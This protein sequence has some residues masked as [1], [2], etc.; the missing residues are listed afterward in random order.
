MLEYATVTDVWSDNA[1]ADAAELTQHANLLVAHETRTA[2][3]RPDA[4]GYPA[5]PL[6]R[7]VFKDAVAAQAR[8]W[9]ENGLKPQNGVQGLPRQASSKSIGSGSI[10]YEPTRGRVESALTGLCSTSWYMLDNAGLLN[11]RPYSV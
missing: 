4:D 9:A 5:D 2:I 1:P 3:Y 8:F 11:G 7:A 10:S 6:I